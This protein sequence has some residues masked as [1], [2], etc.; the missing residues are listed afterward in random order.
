MRAA[1]D[2][3]SFCWH[4]SLQSFTRLRP[5]ICFKLACFRTSPFLSTRIAFQDRGNNRMA[6]DHLSLSYRKA[7]RILLQT[8]L[9][10]NHFSSLESICE[11]TE[12]CFDA[13]RE[14]S[15][16]ATCR[17]NRCRSL[18]E[19]RLDRPATL[20]QNRSYK[21]NSTIESKEEKSKAP[22]KKDYLQNRPKTKLQLMEI[23]DS[24][25]D[26]LPCLIVLIWAAAM[27]L[28]MPT[29]SC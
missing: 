28:S 6:N 1:N 9:D 3:E 25:I 22:H 12:F 14:A 4:K 11:G 17:S 27:Y 24:A 10:M 19:S 13:L 2:S 23:V 16:S 7:R 15:T 21:T 29:K 18:P 8:S 5:P 26:V 20:P